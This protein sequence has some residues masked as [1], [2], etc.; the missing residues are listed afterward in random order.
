M[1]VVR[2]ASEGDRG[3]IAEISKHYDSN[4]IRLLYNTWLQQGNLYVAEE[5]GK[6]IGFCCLAF[7][8]ATEAQIL[9]IR[10]LPEYQ[11]ETVGKQFV[12]ALMQVAQGR[13]CNIVRVITSTE[14]WETQAALQRNLYFERRGAWVIG[15]RE[16]MQRKNC[17]GLRIEP[18][19]P[20]M[21]EDIWQFLQYSQTYRRSEGLIFTS[22]YAFRSFSKAYLSQL[23]EEGQVYVSLEDRMLAGV[24]CARFEGDTMVLSYIDARPHAIPDLLQGIICRQKQ[25]Y[26]VSAV[27]M[28]CYLEV[29][30]LLTHIV[31]GHNPDRWLVMEKEVSPLALSRD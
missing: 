18:S 25:Q 19:P 2:P 4:L 24:A 8:A 15:Y 22:G 5:K 16:K 21:L 29:K 11:K 27:P 23:L 31:E 9:G 26:L 17:S 12:I 14:N 7:P 10:L 1:V 13:G 3:I 30:P 28:D 6:T 20:E